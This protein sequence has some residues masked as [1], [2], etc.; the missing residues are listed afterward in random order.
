MSHCQVRPTRPRLNCPPACLSVRLSVCGLLNLS[1]CQD[2]HQS[3]YLTLINGGHTHTLTHEHTD[4]MQKA[5]S[6]SIV[7]PRMTHS[8]KITHAHTHSLDKDTH[9]RWFSVGRFCSPWR[10]CVCV[11]SFM[12]ADRQLVSVESDSERWLLENL[13]IFFHLLWPLTPETSVI[14]SH[15]WS[16]SGWKTQIS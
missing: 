11:K 1:C 14:L 3:D 15:S 7:E 2:S 6:Q 8:V 10:V 13:V 9:F 16:L 12:L 4:T 5:S